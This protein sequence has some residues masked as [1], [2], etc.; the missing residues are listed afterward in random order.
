MMLWYLHTENTRLIRRGIIF[1]VLRPVWSR[2]FNVILWHLRH[3]WPW[4]SLRGHSR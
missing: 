1:D 3:H 2:H 4:I